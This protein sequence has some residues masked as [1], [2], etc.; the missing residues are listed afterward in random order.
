VF[1]KRVGGIGEN[2]LAILPSPTPQ[3]PRTLTRGNWE[4]NFKPNI[5]VTYMMRE[6]HIQVLSRIEFLALT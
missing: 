6:H 3:S 1:G 5:V 4:R 2:K